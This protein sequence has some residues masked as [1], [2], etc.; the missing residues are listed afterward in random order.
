[1]SSRLLKVGLVCAGMALAGGV[2]A[3]Q[4]AFVGHRAAGMGGANAA[5]VN[6]SSAQWHNPAAFGF[7]GRRP[8]PVSGLVTNAITNVLVSVTDSFVTNTVVVAETNM[9]V[10]AETVETNAVAVSA[11]MDT[12]TVAESDV[13][14]TN[15]VVESEGMDTNVAAEAVVETADTNAA[16]KEIGMDS[17]LAA[18][19]KSETNT[20]V[21]LVTNMVVET[22]PV[23]NETYDISYEEEMVETVPKRAR[24]DNA[25][26]GKLGFGW[27]ILGV[28]VGYTM[29]D[30]MPEYLTQLGEVDFNA[31]DGTGV[32]AS[33]NGVESML[34][35]GS[36]LYGL[37]S[38][39]KNALYVDS[40][41]GMNF[42]IGHIGFGVRMFG[43]AAGYVDY[44]DTANLG[45]EQTQTD[46]INAINTAAAADGFN[47]VGYTYQ[48]INPG[49]LSISGSAGGSDAEAY[50]DSKLTQLRQD[51][52][53]NGKNI[54]DAVFIMNQVTYGQDPNDPASSSIEN[55]KSSV[56]ARGFAL[57]EIPVSYGHAFNDNLS[58]GITAKGMYGTVTGTK[59][60]YAD[61]NALDD[62]MNSLED[63]TEASLNFGLDLGVLYR[64]KMLQFGAVAHNINAPTFK[65]FDDVIA[66]KNDA[67]DV[68]DNVPIHVPDYTMD[69]QVTLGAAFIPSK[70]FMVEMSYDLLE[71]GTLLDHYNIQR[72]SYGTELDLW[73]LAFRLGMYN[74]LAADWQDWVATGGV[75]VNLFIM[76]LDVGGAYSIGANTDYEGTEIPEEARAYAALSC[77]F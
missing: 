17:L 16:P 66:I 52:T 50:I 33:A 12:N 26:L 9:V 68:V 45:V 69:P 20:I 73:L 75:G 46:F 67:G 15:T 40:T 24:V 41:A 38:N 22:V 2:A 23:T 29:T 13:V 21:T 60:R 74:N 32:D 6:D 5:T 55:N 58:V 53:V 59:V 63:N 1:M 43:E 77:E 39:P 72:I 44:L 47:P 76:R 34:L 51:G 36:S 64:M 3:E 42:R 71:T 57:M 25:R 65:G 70:R 19:E 31:F 10:E 61:G 35:L 48:S 62:A 30:D 56:T 27:N 28:G 7:F 54:N 37:G 18:M 11:E 49:D 8:D 14:E 4:F